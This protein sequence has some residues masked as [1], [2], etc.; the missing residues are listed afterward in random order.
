M[1]AV[2]VAVV[3]V[4]VAARATEAGRAASA[5][6]ASAVV[7]VKAVARVAARLVAMATVATTT[8]VTVSAVTVTEAERTATARVRGVEH[9][10]G[11][12]PRVRASCAS[13]TRSERVAFSGL[14]G[15]EWRRMVMRSQHVRVSGLPRARPRRRERASR[16]A[17]NNNNPSSPRVSQCLHAF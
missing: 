1:M 17:Y 10:A 13:G 7:T 5:R 8:A 15:G 6:V 12:L 9:H 11:H 16:F 14:V 4:A 2:K 3:A